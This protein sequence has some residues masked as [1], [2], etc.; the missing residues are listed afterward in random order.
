MGTLSG[1]GRGRF[2]GLCVP[3]LSNF[4]SSGDR[5][6]LFA[7]RVPASLSCR[8]SAISFHHQG[9]ALTPS[10]R[11][12]SLAAGHPAEGRSPTSLPSI[13]RRYGKKRGPVSSSLF[14]M[15]EGVIVYSGE[16]LTWPNEG[17]FFDKA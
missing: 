8:A 2:K 4:G 3:L 12:F 9:Y 6:G 17:E 5:D 7:C 1:H 14:W 15:Q 11:A 13:A 10:K 16:L